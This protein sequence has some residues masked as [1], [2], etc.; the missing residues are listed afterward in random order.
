[1]LSGANTYGGVTDVKNGVAP[2]Q[3][4]SALGT[5]TP[6]GDVTAQRAPS[7]KRAPLELESDLQGEPVTINGNG[8]GRHPPPGLNGHNT[9]ALRNISGNNTFTGTLTLNTNST[10]GVDSG[11][12]LTIGSLAGADR[13]R[14]P[15]SGSAST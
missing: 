1:M 15:S 6:P 2:R 13:H 4:P 7:S 14:P 11:Y 12:Q 9:G 8:Y 10:I 3:Q 5:S